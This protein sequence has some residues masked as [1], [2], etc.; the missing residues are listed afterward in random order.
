VDTLSGDSL[1]GSVSAIDKSS[2][3]VPSKK[4]KRSQVHLFLLPSSE[5]NEILANNTSEE[6]VISTKDVAK[7]EMN[8]KKR[9]GILGVLLTILLG[10]VGLFALLIAIVIGVLI[11]DGGNGSSSSSGTTTGGSGSSCYIA[12]MAYGDINAPEVNSLRRFRD[13]ILVNYKVGRQ[14]INWYY[15]NAPDFV[16]KHESKLWLHTLCRNLLNPFVSIINKFIK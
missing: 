6:L 9:M 8:G 11:S 2:R 14:F 12:T 1:M 16:A 5:K 3:V 13:N 4:E 7:V 15:A 10:I